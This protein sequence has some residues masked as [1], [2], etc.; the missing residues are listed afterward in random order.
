MVLKTKKFYQSKPTKVIIEKF[1][2]GR[3]L[4][5][6]NWDL[7]WIWA[8]WHYRKKHFGWSWATFDVGFFKFSWAKVKL[9]K[10][11]FFLTTLKKNLK[12]FFVF[13]SLFLFSIVSC[14]NKVTSPQGLSIMTLLAAQGGSVFHLTFIQK[15]LI[16]PE[17]M[18]NFSIH[19]KIRVFSISSF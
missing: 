6:R 11:F 17:Y 14:S 19:L 5:N 12:N 3:F 10:I 16:Y 4:W 15:K 9:K 8:G 18:L 13:Y 1:C 2:S 7:G